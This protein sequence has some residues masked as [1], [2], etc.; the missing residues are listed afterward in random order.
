[1]KRVVIIVFVLVGVFFMNSCKKKDVEPT[2]PLVFKSLS[3]S[4]SVFSPGGSV[5]L[6]ADVS[7][8]NV[9]YNWTYNS[10]SISGTG[11]SVYYSNEEIGAH[12]VLCTVIDGAGDMLAK[13]IV[14]TVQ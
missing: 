12:T 7:G 1:M 11:N 5:N 9:Q 14:L 13:Q 6:N 2:Q 8:L 10:G 4:S 3:S